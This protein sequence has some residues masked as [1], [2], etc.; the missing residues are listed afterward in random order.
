MVSVSVLVPEERMAEFYSLLGRWYGSAPSI[1]KTH[2]RPSLQQPGRRRPSRYAPLTKFLTD[3]RGDATEISFAK[4]EEILGGDLPGS[5][6][7]FRAFW[8]NSEKLTQARGWL[9]AGWSVA[10]LDLEGE[11]VKFERA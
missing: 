5:A 11:R 4:V 8:A 2:G 3:A 9:E 6:R 7:K 1:S 10:A